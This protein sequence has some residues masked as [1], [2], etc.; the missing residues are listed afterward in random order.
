MTE[1]LNLY[2]VTFKGVG[3][4]LP[5][6]VVTNDDLSE[7]VETNDEWI[8]SRSGF[9]QRRFLQGDETVTD[10]SIAAAKDALGFAGMEGHEIDLIIHASGT[11][12]NIY[13]CSAGV[14]Q[15]AI[16]ATKAYGFD[17]SMACSGLIYALTIASQFI[18]T[19]KAK[20]VLLVASDGHSRFVDWTDRSTCVLFGD[21]AGAFVISQQEAD[22][23]SDVHYLDLY[24]DGS[25]GCQL[26]L[27][28]NRSN[29]PMVKPR[30]EGA[31]LASGM[32]TMQGKSVFKFAVEDVLNLIRKAVDE[33]GL[34]S[35]DIDYF[36][37]HQA[38]YRI[39][40]AM[41]ERFSLSKEQV[42]INLENYG[43]TSAASIPLAMVDALKDGRIQPGSRLLLCG[44]GAGLAVA[45]AIVDWH[46]VDKRN[47]NAI[48]AT[49]ELTMTSGN[50]P[51]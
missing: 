25:R 43:N 28:N 23:L 11:S 22:K 32:V 7:I 42:I 41:A 34:K 33:A 29:A 49:R 5:P 19:G 13:P 48:P 30:S 46:A 27:Q 40:D 17:I 24:L 26:T 44:F 45:T 14:V 39:L 51:G 50:V 20:N 6:T 15:H 16:G 10:L 4:A 9:K 38:N 1:K 31:L 35:D 21:G 36:V 18:Q 37:M 3:A 12:E 47:A 8:T 2:G